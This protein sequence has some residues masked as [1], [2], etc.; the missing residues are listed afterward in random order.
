MVSP[1]VGLPGEFETREFGVAEA[2]GTGFMLTIFN[3]FLP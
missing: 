2:A 1:F 3:N